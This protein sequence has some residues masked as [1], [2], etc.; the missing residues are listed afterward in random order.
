MPPHKIRLK[1][2]PMTCTVQDVL[3]YLGKVCASSFFCTHVFVYILTCTIQ[4][5]L[6]YLGNM[7]RC[8][9][10]HIFYV[11]VCVHTHIFYVCVCIMT[12][13]VY[14]RVYEYS[15]ILCVCVCV[16]VCLLTCTLQHVITHL[17]NVS[18]RILLH[19]YVCISSHARCRMSSHIL[20]RCEDVLSARLYF[21]YVFI[22][23][24]MMHICAYP[25]LYAYQ[26]Q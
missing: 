26:K 17:G 18:R 15:H 8:V 2:L 24:C 12:C 20:T 1:N 6:A 9:C 23:M 13:I 14:V 10:A 22:Y 5:V 25:Y 3:T 11:R 7:C 16:C 4:D 19:T 21:S